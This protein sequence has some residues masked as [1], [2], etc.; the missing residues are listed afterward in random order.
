MR[1][2]QQ[3]L[4]RLDLL[5]VQNP[6]PFPQVIRV[7]Q[8]KPVCCEASAGSGLRELVCELYA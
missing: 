7:N 6:I 2:D 3:G 8:S 5:H 4:N 1:F